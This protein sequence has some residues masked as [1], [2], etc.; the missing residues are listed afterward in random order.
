MTRR[1]LS[2]I[3]PPAQ[4]DLPSGGECGN[5]ADYTNRSRRGY[6]GAGVRKIR[7]IQRVLRGGNKSE[8]QALIYAERFAEGQIVKLQAGTFEHVGPAVAELAGRRR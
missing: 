6:I 3:D 7:V 4:H 5:R 2:K 1:R 8:S